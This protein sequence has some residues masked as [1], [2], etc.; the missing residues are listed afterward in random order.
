L[1]VADAVANASV[2]LTGLVLLIRSLRR[3]DE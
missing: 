1:E 3:G 2:V